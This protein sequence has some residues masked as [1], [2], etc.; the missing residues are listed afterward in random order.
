M[1]K[2]SSG[3]A[4][5]ELELP[6]RKD[7]SH[8]QLELTPAK[9]GECSPWTG[10]WSS[11]SVSMGSI[12]AMSASPHIDSDI[13]RK[14]F[15][16][17]RR[18][19]MSLL[20]SDT[21]NA[22][23]IDVSEVLERVA[24]DDPTNVELKA[25]VEQVEQ[26]QEKTSNLEIHDLIAAGCS[27]EDISLVIYDM[28]QGN[29]LPNFLPHVTLDQDG[30]LDRIEALWY[31]QKYIWCTFSFACAALNYA[32]LVSLN[33]SVF[34][35]VWYNWEPGL[36][37]HLNSAQ[38]EALEEVERDLFQSI[39]F[40]TTRQRFL[41]IASIIATCEMFG[42]VYLLFFALR[43]ISR[44]ASNGGFAKAHKS[45]YRAY[46]AIESL[47]R[48]TIPLMGTFSAIKLVYAV[49]PALLY[50]QFVNSV[51]ECG[52]CRPFGPP[53][54]IQMV[55]FVVSRLMLGS[56]AVMAFGV[57]LVVISAK[58]VNPN[59]CGIRAWAEVLAL[60]N[61]CIGSV[62]LEQQLQDRLFLFIFGGNDAEFQ[63]DER[64]LRNVYRCRVAKQVWTEF[65][66]E[67]RQ[68]VKAI[69]LLTTFNHYDLQT[70]LMEDT[71]VPIASYV[72]GGSEPL[73]F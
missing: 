22:L 65:A 7:L 27:I 62:R 9:K 42:V 70:L 51:E 15:V 57:K 6:R 18:H 56:V 73:S 55:W 30:G 50:Q 47:F 61:Q 14:G 44:F 31:W 29:A 11:R 12:S 43:Q 46:R 21:G 41:A 33:W 37:D 25:M 39:A 13:K 2:R 3:Y 5:L 63:D 72:G 1:A 48:E 67:K 58:L 23:G 10:R 49:H 40:T 34:C 38:R 17:W 19:G 66:I 64:A 26:S 54:M 69:T 28:L 8:R 4:Q 20:S 60:M 71:A 59:S 45:E 35:S 36:N 32:M 24:K 52:C 16:R 68:Y 53:G